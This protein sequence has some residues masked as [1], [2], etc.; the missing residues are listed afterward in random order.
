MTTPKNKKAFRTNPEGQRGQ[1]EPLLSPRKIA[2]WHPSQSRLPGSKRYIVLRSR[3]HAV[4]FLDQVSQ[5]LAA[6]HEINLRSIHH[7]Q[8]RLIIVKKELIICLCHFAEVFEGNASLVFFIPFFDS[9]VKHFGTRSEI[10]NQIGL[11]HS[12][13]Q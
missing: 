3:T 12:G 9:F 8:R 1:E 4:D 2:F 6:R 7:Q 11:R 13:V 10:E 5:I